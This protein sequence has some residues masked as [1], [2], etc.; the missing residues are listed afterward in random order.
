MT[1]LACA[2]AA[3]I[4]VLALGAVPIVRDIALASILYGAMRLLVG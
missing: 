1:A 4:V 2:V 3:S